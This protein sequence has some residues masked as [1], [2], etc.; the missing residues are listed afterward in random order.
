M[1]ILLDARTATPHFPGIGRYAGELAQ[2]LSA[3]IKGTGDRMT[4]IVPPKC[5]FHLEETPDTS[6]TLCTRSPFET[7]QQQ[8]A[9]AGIVRELKPDIYHSPYFLMPVID[10]IPTV[11]TMHDCIP[12][13]YPAESTMQAR[14]L[15]RT[16]AGRALKL[17]T[18]AIAVSETTKQ[19]CVKFFPDTAA[20]FH[21]IPHG[22]N[23]CF[24]PRGEE[25]REIVTAAYNTERPFILYFGSN[26]PH[27]NLTM[28]LEGYGRARPLLGGRKLVIAG[29]GS[30][31]TRKDASAIARL[32]MQ[33]AVSWIGGIPEKA[34]PALISSA[35]ALVLPSLYEGFGLPVLEAFA[36]GTPVACSG[37]PCLKELAGTAA[38][39]F[40]P[41]SAD[42]MA[43]GLVDAVSG[44]AKT[45]RI[46]EGLSIATACRWDKV[47]VATMDVYR[48][49]IAAA[50]SGKLPE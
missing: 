48:K 19:D 18:T 10:S 38:V 15:F 43:Q 4:V 8:T 16:C 2:A 21:T 31:K 5:T 32:D 28:L 45:K 40:D 50:K 46:E 27:K 9:I 37:I 39:Y 12:L 35:D 30:D 34:L 29:F 7:R 17:C 24:S 11:L 13:M 1:H 3:L 26:R 49:T 20:K 6:V 47:A 22:V 33:D 42:A 23:A 25:Q 36:C 14:L 41:K 44:E